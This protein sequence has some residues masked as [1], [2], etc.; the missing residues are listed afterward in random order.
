MTIGGLDNKLL[1][2]DYSC[3]IYWIKDVVRV[4]DMKAVTDFFTTL[5]NSWNNRNNFIFWGKKED[6]RTI[7]ERVKTLCHEFK[8]HILVN[9]LMLPI[10]PT[11]KKWEK[12]HC[13]FA[14]INFSATILNEKTGYG[15]IVRDSNGFV[16]GGVGV[17]KVLLWMLT[18]L[19]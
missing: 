13:S 7:W 15:V 6:V 1:V 18:G 3:C 4:L 8:I 17:L 9:T 14:K 10:T 12:P 16:L 11:C 19:S 5:W 2:G